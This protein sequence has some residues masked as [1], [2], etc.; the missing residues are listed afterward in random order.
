MSFPKNNHD[1]PS[2]TDLG[3]VLAGLNASIEH[4]MVSLYSMEV[5]TINANGENPPH[6]VKRFT[7]IRHALKEQWEAILG[8][9]RKCHS[10]GADVGLLRTAV[11][12][13]S[14]EDI[15]E[16][17][18]EMVSK[19]DQCLTEAK[20]LEQG[21]SGVLS[22]Y[23]KHKNDLKGQ[24]DHPKVVVDVVSLRNAYTDTEPHR[25]PLK[26]S[27]NQHGGEHELVADSFKSLYPNG[28][29]VIS[30]FETST[31]GV[32]QRLQALRRFLETQSKI[33][34]QCLSE[35]DKPTL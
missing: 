15:R 5:A 24:L 33:C 7:E 20:A 19:C 9:L 13:E 1:V 11:A 30:D 31:H 23:E 26:G 32:Y 29:E 25:D 22:A 10:F 34:N 27:S 35:L 2:N 14:K 12:N 16:F 18:E 8:L 6:Q 3:P 21:H 28:K 17:L 4:A